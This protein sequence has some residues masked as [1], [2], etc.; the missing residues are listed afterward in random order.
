[1]KF[2]HLCPPTKILGFTWKNLQLP[3]PLDKIFDAHV[4]NVWLIMDNWWTIVLW[5]GSTKG[6]CNRFRLAVSLICAK[7]RIS[8]AYASKAWLFQ[9]CLVQLSK[10]G[11]GKLTPL[12][13]LW[14]SSWLPPGQ[15][16]PRTTANH[17]NCC[18]GQLPP[19]TSAPQDNCFP[20][21][22]P[23]RT[24]AIL[25]NLHSG[26]L[27]PR[28]TATQENPLLG[29]CHLKNIEFFAFIATKAVWALVGFVCNY[30][31]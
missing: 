4:H 29:N 31:L 9:K 18:Q 22:L 27:P 28:T 24:A 30:G 25:E 2:Y 8:L 26:Q 7:V 19:G 6:W 14:L 23:P 20:V 13:P 16:P 5:S 21:Q 10:L 11:E 1:M 17:K 3:S 12:R 15:L